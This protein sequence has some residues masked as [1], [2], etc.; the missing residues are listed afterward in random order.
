MAASRAAPAVGKDLEAVL[1]GP[2]GVVRRR[3]AAEETENVAGCSRRS[4]CQ[5]R[6]DVPRTTGQIGVVADLRPATGGAEDPRGRGALDVGVLGADHSPGPQQQG[7]A[8]LEHP[9]RDRARRRRRTARGAGRG[10]GPRGRPTPR[11]RAGCTAGCRRPRRPSRPG[12]R[13]PSAMSPWR[14]ST[15][16]PARLRT[17]QRCAASSSS[18]AC[19]RACGT[20]SATARAIAPEPVHEVDHHRRSPAA[21]AALDRPAGQQLGLRARHEHPGPDGRARR[22]G[23]PRCRAGAAAARGRPAAPPGRR[24]PRPGSSSADSTSGS[25]PRVVPST[26]A[27]SS[28][29]SRSGEATPAS[30][31]RSAAARRSDRER[32]HCSS[33]SSRPARSASTALATSAS[34]S[35]SST[36]SRL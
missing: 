33:A 2:R 4:S 10:R 25:R 29:A 13:T 34:R 16:V 19:T 30:R 9:H 27:S 26:W 28:S 24:T 18:T 36:V 5:S 31:S 35:P 6:R 12:R 21:V 1:I 3:S 20:S 14:R 8:A 15:P 22:S 23:T 32:A 7:G 17:A 11:R